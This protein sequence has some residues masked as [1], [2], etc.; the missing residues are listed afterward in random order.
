MQASMGPRSGNRGYVPTCYPLLHLMVELQW[1]HGPVTV[2]MPRRLFCGFHNI[3]SRPPREAAPQEWTPVLRRLH[4]SLL[5][6]IED[7]LRNCER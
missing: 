4:T 2:V 1:V 3:L 6:H 7:A 5:L